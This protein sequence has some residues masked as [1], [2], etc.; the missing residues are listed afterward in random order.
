MT[1]RKQYFDFVFEWVFTCKHMCVIKTNK[2]C[3]KLKFSYIKM[4][5]LFMKNII[6]TRV[7]W[8][9]AGLSQR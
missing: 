7:R 2:C 3:C 4:F 8:K 6:H 5:F 9:V 1:Q